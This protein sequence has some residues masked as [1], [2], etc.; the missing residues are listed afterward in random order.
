[1]LAARVRRFLKPIPPH[2]ILMGWSAI[3]LFP[4]WILVA[5]SFKIQRKIFQQPFMPPADIVVNG[6][7]SAWT[8]GHFDIYFRNTI[9]VTFGALFMI[10]FFGSLAA[11]A[12]ANWQ[13]HIS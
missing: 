10:L 11:Y 7:I 12:L 1:M 8:R 6:Y 4:I 2:L 9:F 13:S 5:N 3:V